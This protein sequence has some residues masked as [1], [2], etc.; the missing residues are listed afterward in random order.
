MEKKIKWFQKQRKISEAI[1]D[2]HYE[3]KLKL[4]KV[5]RKNKVLS[6]QC[7]HNILETILEENF[8]V[9][10]EQYIIKVEH[11]DEVSF[12]IFKSTA[13]YLAK[14]QSQMIKFTKITL[15]S[16]GVCTSIKLS[17]MYYFLFLIS[18]KVSIMKKISSE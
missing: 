2:C 4:K 6:L 7:Q 14:K 15:N 11:M 17:I 5:S 12:Y 16:T 1:Q 13:A 18:N 3:S 8:T 10:Y 9:L